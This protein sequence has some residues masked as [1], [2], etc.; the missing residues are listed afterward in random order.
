MRLVGSPALTDRLDAG[1][2]RQVSV[3]YLAFRP[4]GFPFVPFVSFVVHALGR[5]EQARL[6]E[7]DSSGVSFFEVAA[8]PLASA[9]MPRCSRSA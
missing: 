3:S 8:S 2:G 9:S 6:H 5:T 7:P 1:G 4:V